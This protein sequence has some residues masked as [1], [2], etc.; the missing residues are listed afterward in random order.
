[1]FISETI[2]FRD[3]MLES[4]NIYSIFSF[5]GALPGVAIEIYEFEFKLAAE[6]AYRSPSDAC[7]DLAPP[8]GDAE[9][10]PL[11]TFPYKADAYYTNVV[12]AQD[13]DNLSNHFFRISGRGYSYHNSLRWNTAIGCITSNAVYR[14]KVDYRLHSC[15]D[16]PNPE[17]HGFRAVSYTHLRAHET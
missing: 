17:A 12:V 5:Q 15:D 16:M 6:E 11:S 1:M 3:E 4:T 13:E 14:V 2:V 9:L 7:P 10:D 8:N